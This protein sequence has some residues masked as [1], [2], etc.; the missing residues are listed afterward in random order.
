LTGAIALNFGESAA[1]LHRDTPGA[2]LLSTDGLVIAD[3]GGADPA[4]N[5]VTMIRLSPD[6]ADERIAAAVA[7]VA[8][9]GREFSWWVDAHATPS[10]VLSRLQAAGL[11]LIERIP[12]MR[13]D[14]VDATD[15][16]AEPHAAGLEIRAVTTT[17]G[18]ADFA[19]V[20]DAS[21]DPPVTSAAEFY[22]RA[23]AEA[24]DPAGPARFLV[25]YLDG[26]AVATAQVLLAAGVAGLYN[27]TTL[28]DHRRRGYGS[29]LTRAALR[30]AAAEGY[31][32]AVLESSAEGESVYR[33][34]GFTRC[35]EFAM[36][37]LEP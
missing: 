35:G 30:L 31:A 18:L 5:S 23:A 15:T 37:M 26:V 32:T 1:H 17:A 28:P 16:L 27:I 29:A 36:L 14:L 33:P 19:A 25:G 6:T 9:T 4:F 20:V 7:T 34:L 11:T 12:T 21:M 2:G 13:L 8:A 22:A 24:P 3:S 10:D